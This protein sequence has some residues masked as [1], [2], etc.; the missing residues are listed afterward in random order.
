MKRSTVLFF[1][2]LLLLAGCAKEKFV[3]V[4]DTKPTEI[5]V[6]A[7][8]VQMSE[9]VVQAFSTFLDENNIVPGIGQGEMTEQMGR[10]SYQGEQINSNGGIHAD[11]IGSF[12]YSESDPQGR[13]GFENSFKQNQE[14][15]YANYCNMLFTRVP[16]EGLSMPFDITFQDDM[17][18][19]L[20]KMEL[21]MDPLESFFEGADT[22]LEVY[23]SDSETVTIIDFRDKEAS[24]CAFALLYTQTYPIT[25]EN[26]QEISVTRQVRLQF[27][28]E[29][30]QLNYLE[31][32]VNEYYLT[33]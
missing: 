10:Y 6:K 17:G 30:C 24:E 23:Q 15:Q 31:L 13:Y 12:S 29:T 22:E 21:D 11:G 8:D 5:A 9:E 18:Q 3:S 19:V 28:R 4:T 25:D 16:L 2:C 14:T 32:K 26:G 20:E 1:I 27:A 33:T 7:A